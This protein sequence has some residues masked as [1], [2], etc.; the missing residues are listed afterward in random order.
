MIQ[1]EKYLRQ[2]SRNKLILLKNKKVLDLEYIDLGNYISNCIYKNELNYKFSNR[3]FTHLDELVLESPT[4][5]KTF[6]NYLAL[7]N[8]GILFEPELK[9]N[10][11]HFLEWY[12]QN[13]ILFIEWEGSLDDNYLYFLT[14]E[15]GFKVAIKNLSH[16]V[17]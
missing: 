11:S 14:K 6:G 5:H 3:I 15:N 10:V 13:L 17:I 12:S 4:N 16:I 8:I 2:P 7:Y 9:V 1:I